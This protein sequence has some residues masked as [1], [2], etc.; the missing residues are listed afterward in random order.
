MSDLFTEDAKVTPDQFQY[1]D[2][3]DLSLSSREDAR[4]KLQE[5]MEKKDR[6]NKAP[7]R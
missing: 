4:R 5:D 6:K 2:G 7:F 1:T 3:R